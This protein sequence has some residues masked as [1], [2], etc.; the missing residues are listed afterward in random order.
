MERRTLVIVG[1]TCSGKT[2]LGIKIAK[3]I[4]GEIISVDSRQFYKYLDIGSAK[5]SPDELQSVKHYFIDNLL[6][7][8]YY[9]A[10][11]FE[12]EA[13][14]EIDGII[15]R[16]R[17]PVAVGGS[18]MYVSALVDGIFA[19][20]EAGEKCRNKIKEELEVYGKEFIYEKLKKV[21][22]VSADKMSPQN[23]KRVVRALEVFY[24]T[25]V[26]IWTHHKEYKR[27]FEIT[28]YQFGLLWNRNTLYENINE[29]VDNMIKRGLINEVRNILDM[30]FSKHL[31]SL[32]TVGYKEIILYLE[33][34]ISLDEAVELI[35]RSSRR[36]AKRQTTWFKRDNRISWMEIQSL[37]Q[38][39][40]IAEKIVKQYN[41]K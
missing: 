33:N 35:K 22:P 29:R 20:K 24:S 25:G 17:V 8:E 34:K 15:N 26:P 21:D 11:L 12:K 18:G 19:H 23:W 28:F 32:N 36:L 7:D 30:G 40:E 27:N 3:M 37:E 16:N 13:L 1:P 2:A 4:N 10:S 5:P 9:N 6:P 38:I 14:V 41:C 39:D 31:N